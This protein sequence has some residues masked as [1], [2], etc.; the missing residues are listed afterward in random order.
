[1]HTGDV[2]EPTSTFELRFNDPV[3]ASDQVG[4]PGQASPLRITPPLAGDWVWLSRRSGVFRPTEPPALGRDYRL[5]LALGG[6]RIDRVLRTPAFGFEVGS[7]LGFDTNDAPVSPRLRLVF[8]ADVTAA[9]AAGLLG[10]EDDAGRRLAAVVRQGTR[11]GDPEWTWSAGGAVGTWHERFALARG[12]I[13]DA[14]DLESTTDPETGSAEFPHVLAVLP[15]RPLPPGEG[16]RLRVRAGLA[17]VEPG[18]RLSRD[19]VIAVGTIRPFTPIGFAG[20]SA[21]N[22]GRRIEVQFSKPLAEGLS[23]SELHEWISVSPRPGNLRLAR[24]WRQVSLEGDYQLDTTYTVRVKQGLP[25]REAVTQPHDVVTNLSFVPLRPRLYFPATTTEQLSAGR[26]TFDLL[27]LNLPEVQVRAKQL[28]RA[29]L[30]PALRGFR[31]YFRGPGQAWVMDEPY[32]GLDYNVLPGRTIWQTNLEFRALPDDAVRRTLSWEAVLS[33]RTTGAVFLDAAAAPQTALDGKWP[34]TQTIVQLTDLGLYWRRAESNLWALAFSYRSGSALAGVNLQLVTDED[35]V[36]AEARTL[37]TGLVAL[38]LDERAAWLVAEHGEDLRAAEVRSHELYAYNP[39]IPVRS[40]WDNTVT[41]RRVFLFSERPVYR[42]GETLHLKALVRDVS[43]N[44]L[45]IPAGAHGRLIAYDARNRQFHDTNVAFSPRGSWDADVPLPR[46]VRG[47]YRFELS[48]GTNDVHS[49]YIQVQDYTP[50][51]FTLTLRAPASVPAGEP[52]AV[53][54]EA[55]HLFGDEVARGHLRWSSRAEDEGFAPAGFE[56]FIFCSGGYWQG[57]EPSRTALTLSGQT[58]YRRGQP[59]VLEP[60][61]PVQP[62]APQPRSVEL[63]AELTDLNQQTITAAA[64]FRRH[65]SAF[66]LGIEGA[67]GVIEAGAPSPLRLI[68]V[69]A[70]GRPWSNAVTARVTLQRIEW[71]TV[72]VVGAGGTVAYRSERLLHPVSTNDVPVELPVWTG[73]RWASAPEAI[74]ASTFTPPVAGLYLLEARAQDPDGREVVTTVSYHAY[75]PEPERLAWDYRSPAT[76]ELVPDRTNYVAGEM[77]TVLVKAPFNGTAI[78]SVDREEVRRSFVTNLTGNAP[79]LQ[80]P[81][82]ATDAP[83][84]YLSVMLLRGLADSPRTIPEP[85]YSLGGCQ[86]VVERPATRLELRLVLP[87]NNVLPAADVPVEVHVRDG[88]GIPRPD[89]EVTLYAVDEGVLN[90]VGYPLPDPH[91]FFHEVRPLAVWPHCTLPNV[92]PEDPAYWRFHNKGY[93]GGGGG[94][95]REALRRNFQACAFWS[96]S[97]CTDAQGRIATRFTAPDSLTRYRVF[98]VAH[99]GADSFG[100]TEASFRVNKPLQI[101]PAPLPFAHVGDQI[102]LRAVIHNRTPQPGTVVVELEPNAAEAVRVGESGASQ[103]VRRIAIEPAT[104]T[105]VDIPVEFTRPGETRWVWRARFERPDLATFTDA[106]EAKL[107]VHDPSPRLREVH[108]TRDATPRANLLARANPQLL[109]GAGERELVVRIANTRLVELGEAVRHLLE[110]PYGCAE[111][112]VS[113]LLPWL[114]LGDLTNRVP[115]LARPPRAVRETVESGLNRLFFMQTGLGGLAFW[116]GG[117]EPGFWISGYAGVAFGLAAR[118]GYTLPPGRLASLEQ[119]LRKGLSSRRE[120]LAPDELGEQALALWALTLA[121]TPE[122]GAAD[123]LFEH[124]DRMDAE[125]RALLALSLPET[126]TARIEEL[127]RPKLR[128]PAREETWFGSAARELGIALMAW[129]RFGPD[130]PE[131]DRLLEEL[132]AARQAGHWLTT[133]GNAWAVLGLAEYV[134]HV[135][136]GLNAGGGRVTWGT[137]ERPFELP[138]A[139]GTFETVFRGSHPGGSP[140]LWLENPERRRWFAQA[141]IAGHVGAPEQ[142]RQDRGFAVQRR[143]EL[144]GDDNV[145]R[146]FTNAR[147]GDRVLVTLQLEARET[148]HYVAIEDPAPAIFELVNPAFASPSAAAGD[149]H[150]ASWRSDFQEIRQ[151]RAL[152]FRDRLPPGHYTLRYLARVRA[153]GTAWAPGAKIEE[154]YHPER[155]GLTETVRVHAAPALEVD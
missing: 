70:E 155:F 20:R 28:D 112:T 152:F 50:A 98:A 128:I 111:Q 73:T 11:E 145:A 110:Y 141:T 15:S 131:V 85:E 68:A 79:A 123:R 32:L 144:L 13:A 67:N 80:I 21:L 40:S 46:E 81:L 129:C 78:V 96:A 154:M 31:S 3:V 105:T 56:D 116:P 62:A 7:S 36:L 76:L 27:S 14:P 65:S 10:F 38:P 90:L 61:V 126:D 48:L 39:N 89:A 84:V 69:D 86:L 74:P 102:E 119:Y 34:G 58:E 87:T 42:P 95:S 51:A 106:V 94:K 41:T 26:R 55:R 77:A 1:M 120:P 147:V 45:E 25:S 142:P 9:A 92:L 75:S 139:G 118:Q 140:P 66:Y 134:R 49:H 107:T 135:E 52:V 132:L 16:W 136:Q 57:W 103:A 54:V 17:S 101:T 121:E 30:V 6:A 71:Q 43:A 23:A 83:A 100:A 104:A 64:R 29:A 130:Q 108:L 44:G 18:L 63:E 153:A 82:D 99:A 124:R 115:A 143:Y 97:L 117:G 24:A 60:E 91:A 146:G 12:G 151:D 8:N 125:T 22:S 133:Q 47:A 93:L 138:E 113:S 59:L 5:S 148:A 114:V 19:E 53:P 2:L 109:E 127:L 122:A 35:D 33:G 149:R 37:D 88:A 137:D 4:I 150:A 72:R